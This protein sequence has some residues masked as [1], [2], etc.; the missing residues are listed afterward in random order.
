MRAKRRLAA[1][2]A[3]VPVSKREPWASDLL[4]LACR[5]AG[6]SSRSVQ[7][8]RLIA[9][10]SG[11]RHSLHSD[12]D[13][14]LALALRLLRFNADNAEWHGRVLLVIFD[15]IVAKAFCRVSSAAGSAA[16]AIAWRRGQGV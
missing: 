16:Q 12:P 15:G 5:P 14:Q 7:G 4:E 9:A 1:N 6:I 10:D 8:L 2:F 3:Q 13:L 11:V